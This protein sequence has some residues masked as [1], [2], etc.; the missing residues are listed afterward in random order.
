[1]AIERER[2]GAALVVAT[3]RAPWPRRPGRGG[4]RSAATV[5][6][7]AGLLLLAGCGD[8]DEPATD[9]TALNQP[10][11]TATRSTSSPATPRPATPGPATPAAATPIAGTPDGTP[12]PATTVGA[13]ADRIGAAWTGVASFR[14]S[15]ITVSADAPPTA[16]GGP[17]GSPSASPIAGP[18]DPL[19]SA[20]DEVVLP[21]RKRREIVVGDRPSTSIVVIGETI[22]ARGGLVVEFVDP[23][24]PTETWIVLDP[25]TVDPTSPLGDVLAGFL[26]PVRAPLSDLRPDERD[27]PAR[28][29]GQS[30]I[31]GRTCDLYAIVQTTETGERVDVS[32]GVDAT[33]LPCAIATTAGGQTT[34]A[35]YVAF[36][37]P[38]AIE[39]PPGAVPWQP[40]PVATP[41]G[42][43]PQAGA[44]TPAG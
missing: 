41:A 24:L 38:L 5:C 10:N 37:E 19:V 22:Y 26:G 29:T 4:P 18:G 34:T 42:A 33:G 31:E 27:L 28:S 9:P 43:T 11:P 39:P 15:E 6:A 20:N 7:L 17:V 21:D 40:S 23:S 8:D 36:N 12:A 3:R 14:V 30:V 44:P 13:L 32:V 35:I 2:I 16:G 1:M 25:A